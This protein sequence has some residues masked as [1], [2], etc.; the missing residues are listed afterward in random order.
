MENSIQLSKR[1]FKNE[2]QTY[3]KLTEAKE[4]RESKRMETLQRIAQIREA[5]IGRSS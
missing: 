2:L 4:E 3:S 1:T 5:S